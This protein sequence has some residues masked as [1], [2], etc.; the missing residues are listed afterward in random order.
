M[1]NKIALFLITILMST[2]AMADGLDSQH[3]AWNVF[4]ITQDEDDICYITSS[5]IK[6]GESGTWKRRGDP[7]ALVTYRQNGIS[8]VSVSS[9]YP[10]KKGSKATIVIDKKDTYNFFTSEETPKIA[11]ARDVAED[12][13]VV[14]SMIRGA[15]FTIKGESSKGTW[16][17]DI[18]SLYG[19]TKAYKRMQTLCEGLHAASSA[20]PVV[21]ET[22]KK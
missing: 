9:G 4:S 14:K 1:R 21:A 7:F 6:N 19:F 17:Q 3:K 15:R 16:S 20:A 5:P 12:K 11:W 8:E 22:K 2:P 10:Y 18:Y 13:K